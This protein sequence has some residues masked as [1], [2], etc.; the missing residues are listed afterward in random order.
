MS[1]YSLQL[2]VL[3]L[4]VNAKRILEIGA[5]P[6]GLSGF[7]FCK[8]MRHNG[9]GCEL[10]SIDIN[11][12]HPDKSVIESA[13]A[14]FDVSWTVLYG[15]SRS[16]PD[17]ITKL[18]K[19][20]LLYIDGDHGLDFVRSDYNRFCPLVRQG[21]FVVFDDYPIANGVASFIHE[22]LRFGQHIGVDWPR[23]QHIRLPYN[24]NDGNSHYVIQVAGP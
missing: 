3:A 2:E 23:N 17:D 14:E 1:G 18:G 16:T 7:A 8:A 13:E 11:P 19:F 12:A 15:D 4:A 20:D 22:D 21:G 10:V 9:L 24:H 6:Q 5:G